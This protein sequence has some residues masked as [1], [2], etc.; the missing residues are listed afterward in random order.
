MMGMV[1]AGEQ[2]KE[3]GGAGDEEEKDKIAK[4]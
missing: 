4:E 1:K 3:E 2:G